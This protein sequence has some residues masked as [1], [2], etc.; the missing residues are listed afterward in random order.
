[1]VQ[2]GNWCCTSKL[3]CRQLSLCPPPHTTIL[4]EKMNSPSPGS[5]LSD[6]LH[7]SDLEGKGRQEKWSWSSQRESF[8]PSG[9]H[10]SGPG[11]REKHCNPCDARQGLWRGPWEHCTHGPSSCT[12]SV[13]ARKSHSLQVS[14]QISPAPKPFLVLH[15]CWSQPCL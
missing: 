3:L 7:F 11:R 13:T 12:A 6:T 10:R 9:K 5:Q 1:M 14:L 2:T 15:R 8:K 4:Q